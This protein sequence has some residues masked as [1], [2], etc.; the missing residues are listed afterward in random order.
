MGSGVSG[1]AV[2]QLKNMYISAERLSGSSLLEL[3]REESFR[4][5]HGG[6]HTFWRGNIEA[7][8]EGIAE[9]TSSLS[10]HGCLTEIPSAEDRQSK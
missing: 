1:K 5:V 2:D 8:E 4:G 3:L 6:G 9:V 10:A 7:L